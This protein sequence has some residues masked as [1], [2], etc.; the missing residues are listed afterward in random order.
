[1]SREPLR[2]RSRREVQRRGS[3]GR[4]LEFLHVSSLRDSSLC[5][6]Q[7]G[8][9]RPKLQL[10]NCGVLAFT[11]KKKIQNER[12]RRSGDSKAPFH[13]YVYDSEAF[14]ALENLLI[15]GLNPCNFHKL[16]GDKRVSGILFDA[17]SNKTRQ[18]SVG[19]DLLRSC[20]HLECLTPPLLARP[21]LLFCRYSG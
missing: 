12:D 11:L 13:V 21:C 9:S 2:R 14:I 1:M 19:V 6:G 5:F 20:F 16:R 7:S 4:S 15:K 8:D 10:L 3:Q 17:E 18:P